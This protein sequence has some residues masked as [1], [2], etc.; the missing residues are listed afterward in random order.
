LDTKH[1]GKLPRSIADLKRVLQAY[2]IDE[3]KMLPSAKLRVPDFL[4]DGTTV[5]AENA[6]DRRRITGM[7]TVYPLDDGSFGILDGI[8]RFWYGHKKKEMTFPCGIVKNVAHDSF[9]TNVLRMWLNHDR[10]SSFQELWLIYWW[11]QNTF[12]SA[13]L[14]QAC[15][16]LE[17][18][19]R[20][21]KLVQT[22]PQE[23][24]DMLELVSQGLLHGA[25]CKL[26]NL[27][28]QQDQNS[29][30]TYFTGM[31]LSQQMQRETL[32]WLPEIAFRNGC[33]IGDV[34]QEEELVSLRNSSILSIPQKIQKIRALLFNLRFPS[35]AVYLKKWE[36]LVNK[37]FPR[38]I[39]VRSSDAFEK[40]Y[41]SLQCTITSPQKALEY[42]Q[43][44]SDIPRDVWATL[45]APVSEGT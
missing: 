17:I 10:S 33:S 25:N 12:G 2:H 34:L 31:G 5:S 15:E 4:I 11:L 1:T 39:Q 28:S 45:I 6:G 18:D 30:V 36:T 27:L 38:G 23:K 42:A 44:L 21:F 29:Y 40:N 24:A 14:F 19:Q 9:M 41:L 8:K 37:H 43:A 32:E 22:I 35:Y 3:V 16:A 26:F 20:D 13:A 7:L